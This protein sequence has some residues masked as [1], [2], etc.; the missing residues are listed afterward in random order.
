MNKTLNKG[1]V[2]H[3]CV[4]KYNGSLTSPTIQLTIDS[5]GSLQGRVG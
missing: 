5:Y 4:D 2:V 1:I 3:G